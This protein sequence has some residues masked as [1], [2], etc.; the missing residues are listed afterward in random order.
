MNFTSGRHEQVDGVS[1]LYIEPTDDTCVVRDYM[2]TYA[3]KYGVE[4]EQY[5]FASVKCD[6]G[7]IHSATRAISSV[8][9]RRE[10]G[11]ET[12]AAR[13]RTQPNRR[14]KHLQR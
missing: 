10:L 13:P 14:P 6:A 1:N 11:A 3:A 2:A 8:F 4:P 5:D 12:V 7:P 9:G